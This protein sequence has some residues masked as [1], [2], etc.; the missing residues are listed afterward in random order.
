MESQRDAFHGIRA[1]L[2]LLLPCALYLA[3][4]AILGAWIIDDAG[5]S[6]AYA[7]SL[8]HGYGLVSQPGR[9][10]VEGFSNFLWVLTLAPAFLVRIFHPVV[11]PKLLGELCVVGAFALV[12]RTLRAATASPWP[13]LVVCLLLAGSPPIVIWSASGLE[14]GLLLFLFSA[15]YACAV[16]RR[17]RWRRWCGVLSALI[18]MT[19]PDGLAYAA[20]GVLV[21]LLE[22]VEKRKVP[23]RAAAAVGEYLASFLLVFGPFLAFRL[24][25]FHLPFPHPYYAKRLF[26]S[27]PERLSYLASHLGQ[28]GAKLVDLCRAV[29]GPPGPVVVLATWVGIVLLAI[30]RRLPAHVSVVAVVQVVAIGV[31]LWM[32]ED[33]MGEYRFAT[34]AVFASL[35]AAIVASEAISRDCFAGRYRRVVMTLVALGTTAI[36]FTVYLPRIA[37]FAGNPPT[38]YAD[39][40]RQYA[41]KYNV[42]ADVLGLAK[43]SILI[44]D[45]GATLMDSRL[46]V[47]DAAGLFEPDVVRTLKRGSPTWYSDHPQFFDWTFETIRPT[48]IVTRG[49]WSYVPWFEKDPRFSRDYVAIDAFED[50]YVQRVY[51]VTLRSGDF[52]RRDALASPGALARLQAGYH[53]PPRAEPLVYRVEAALGIGDPFGLQATDAELRAQAGQNLWPNPQ[54]AAALY[55]QLVARR[56]DDLDAVTDLAAALDAAGRTDEARPAWMRALQL[57]KVRGDAAQIARSSARLEGVIRSVAEEVELEKRLMQVGLDALYTRNDP[58]R[59][60]SVFR[61]ILAHNATHYGATYQLAAAL[62]RVGRI[63]EARAM[64]PR[65]LE[66]ARS[67]GDTSTIALVEARMRSQ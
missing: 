51:G 23:K 37:R 3:S 63:D 49:F 29:A 31:Y 56:P 54:H 6:F 41:L 55:A 52:V 30:R 21:C 8:A 27:A 13:G 19:R 47:Y 64:W 9:V 32:D 17:A 67:Y 35:V 58:E 24:A 42:Y 2:F 16:E 33:W 62:E 4:A 45:A 5:I 20:A 26:V 22:I 43:G 34:P 61:E 36:L 28:L 40:E 39:V 65:V 10:P 12:Q 50:D 46:T 18:A 1:P 60:I 57:A 66:M 59:A 14:N 11:V 44:A 53:P 38:P 25:V 15:F 48:F 7:R